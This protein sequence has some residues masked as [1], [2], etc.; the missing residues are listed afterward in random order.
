MVVTD[1]TVG[2]TDI[3]LEIWDI[4]GKDIRVRLWVSDV[5]VSGKEY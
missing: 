1:N 2:V 3:R 5:T 4:L